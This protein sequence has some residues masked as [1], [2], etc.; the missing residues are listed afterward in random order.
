MQRL[1]ARHSGNRSLI[2]S[3]GKI[4]LPLPYIMSAQYPTYKFTRGLSLT[5]KRPSHE[6]DYWLQIVPKLWM[7]W[8]WRRGAQRQVFLSPIAL[9][10]VFL[11]LLF[12]VLFTLLGFYQL[13]SNFPEYIPIYIQ[14]DATL[15]SLFISGNCSTCF[16]S[17]LHPASGAHTT[18]FTVSATC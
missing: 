6:S 16:G 7:I 3:K 10:C 2:P 15:H 13:V 5:A 12:H 1:W 8:G 9:W 18:V 11:Y 4:S 14:Q 17:Y